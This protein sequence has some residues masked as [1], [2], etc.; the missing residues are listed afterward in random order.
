MSSALSS[1][2]SALLYVAAGS[3]FFLLTTL[4]FGLPWRL[5]RSDA[6]DGNGNSPLSHRAHLEATP[7]ALS[8]T[9]TG[10]HSCYLM[11]NCSDSGQSSG[12]GQF[13]GLGCAV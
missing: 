9:A 4:Y 6:Y 7:N 5:L 10:I 3:G 2:N 8:E 1:F 12:G 11:R 13:V